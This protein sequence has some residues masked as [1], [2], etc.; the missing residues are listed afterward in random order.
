MIKLKKRVIILFQLSFV[1]A[2]SILYVIFIA[3]LIT[4]KLLPYPGIEQDYDEI[5]QKLCTVEKQLDDYLK[6]TK[7]LLKYAIKLFIVKF[8]HNLNMA[9]FYLFF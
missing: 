5:N 9:V 7:K 2:N 3:H 6:E 1:D 8:I 4:G